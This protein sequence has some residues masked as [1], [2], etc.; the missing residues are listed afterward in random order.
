MNKASHVMSNAD[1][2]TLEQFSLQW[3]DFDQSEVSAVELQKIFNKYFDHFPWEQINGDSVGLDAGCGSG[4]WAM[5]VAPRV[6][7]LVCVDASSGAAA[8]AQQR[9]QPFNN[10]AVHACSVQDAPVADGSL[11][12]A[13]CLGVLHYVP[14][15][16]WALRAIARKL[17]PGAPL[18][19][20]VYYALDNRPMWFRAAF[21]VVDLVRRAIASTPYR[22]RRALSDVIAGLVYLPLARLSRALERFGFK[23]QGI[24]LS[25]YRNRSFYTMRTDCLDRFGNHLEHRFTRKE[26]FDLLQECGLTNIVIPDDEPYWRAVAVRAGT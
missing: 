9:L 3:S 11:D 16:R 19:V 14:D 4:R 12:F 25:A 26:L 10:C 2:T 13:Y 6:G 1:A 17:K 15:P 5:F 20:Y 24:P 8:V 7:Q 22:L 21:R 18:L 23:V